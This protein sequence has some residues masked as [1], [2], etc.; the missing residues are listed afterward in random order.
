MPGLKMGGL[1]GADTEQDAQNLWIGDPLS[2]RWVEAGAALLD[3]GKVEAR[4]VGD[5]LDVVLGGQV[6]IGPG[7]GRK[8][9]FTQT[10]DG[11]R[12]RVTEIGVLCAA[13]VARPPASVHGES[14]EVGEPADLPGASRFTA[15]QGAKAI[16]ID[17]S[18]A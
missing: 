6:G 8:L 12:E 11:L 15:G 18:R 1:G 13:A 3:E 17:G 10:R 4:R 9:A 7:N 2:Q 16:Q 14:H 5:R